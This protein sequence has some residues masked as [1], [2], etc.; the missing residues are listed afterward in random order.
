MA[1][2]K[3]SKPVKLQKDSCLKLPYND[4]LNTKTAKKWQ[5]FCAIVSYPEFE[6]TV[7]RVIVLLN[8]DGNEARNKKDLNKKSWCLLRC[9]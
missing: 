8:G 4:K 7:V 2:T 6:I 9:W 5:E 3:I 1:F